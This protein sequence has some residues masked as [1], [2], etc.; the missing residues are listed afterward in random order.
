MADTYR[1]KMKLVS[2]VFYQRDYR[3]CHQSQE[4]RKLFQPYIRLAIINSLRYP[5]DAWKFKLPLITRF[6][7]AIKP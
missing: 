4:I 5:W 7:F 1:T 6:C 2:D 3:K